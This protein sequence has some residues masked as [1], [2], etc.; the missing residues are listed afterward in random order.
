MTNKTPGSTKK[1]CR[2]T[3][4]DSHKLTYYFS[5]SFPFKCGLAQYF[6]NLPQWFLLRTTPFIGS[7]APTITYAQLQNI[8]MKFSKHSLELTTYIHKASGTFKLAFLLKVKA[9]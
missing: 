2:C 9:Q 8:L 5:S 4:S 3:R 1:H 7:S 6:L